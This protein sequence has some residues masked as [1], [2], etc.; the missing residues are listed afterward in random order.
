ADRVSDNLLELELDPIRAA[1]DGSDLQ[2]ASAARWEAATTALVELWQW[3]G[4]LDRVLT[5]A[6]E[7][8]SRRGAA[9]RHE[10]E[11]LLLGQ[12]VV[13]ER[14]EVPLEERS[15]AGEAIAISRATPSLLL[16][17]MS[18]SFDDV[19]ATL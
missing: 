6:A 17:R 16:A 18:D 4:E 9:S 1:L 5:Q 7:L 2:G 15:L 14:R 11:V 10:L 13:V 3:Y 19:K 12:S 8:R